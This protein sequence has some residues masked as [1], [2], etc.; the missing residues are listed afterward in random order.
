MTILV[1]PLMYRPLL[2]KGATRKKA[3]RVRQE[4]VIAR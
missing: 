4:L 2:T 1:T 3:N